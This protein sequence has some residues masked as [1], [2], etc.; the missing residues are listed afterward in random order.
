MMCFLFLL[1]CGF[2]AESLPNDDMDTNAHAW[3]GFGVVDDSDLA[4]ATNPTSRYPPGHSKRGIRPGAE[5]SFP[6]K[7]IPTRVSRQRTEAA[8][9]A[10][11]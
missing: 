1:N 5:R 9:M 4:H 10:I 6:G 2:M 3:W 11:E 7:D 8:S